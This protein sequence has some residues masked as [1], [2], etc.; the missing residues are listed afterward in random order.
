MVPCEKQGEIMV[1]SLRYRA[2]TMKGPVFKY[3]LKILIFFKLIFFDVFRLFDA[4]IL[5]IIFKK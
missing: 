4:L 5:K 2:R 3:F 1:P